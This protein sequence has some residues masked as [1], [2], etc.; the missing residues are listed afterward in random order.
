M[1]L[2]LSAIIMH[3]MPSFLLNLS[4]LD[5][6]FN[7]VLISTLIIIQMLHNVHS[8]KRLSK[9]MTFILFLES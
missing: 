9:C 5:C 2:L 8:S 4:Q 6:L 3:L 7:S 1:K